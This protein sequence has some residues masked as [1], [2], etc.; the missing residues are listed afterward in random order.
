[1]ASE[2]TIVIVVAHAY[3]TFAVT[4]NATNRINGLIPHTDVDI[5]AASIGVDIEVAASIF[6]KAYET[7]VTRDMTYLHATVAAIHV[8]IN[9][10]NH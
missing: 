7:V 4:D 2:F 3:T 5:D 9:G 1:M 8:N 10:R 6:S